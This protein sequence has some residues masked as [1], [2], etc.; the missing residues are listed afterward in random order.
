MIDRKNLE[1]QLRTET[2]RAANAASELEKILAALDAAN[3]KAVLL[4]EM[5]EMRSHAIDHIAQAQLTC[6]TQQ[7]TLTRSLSV[8]EQGASGE[9]RESCQSAEMGALRCTVEIIRDRKRE[10]AA[11]DDHRPAEAPSTVAPMLLRCCYS[12]PRY[13]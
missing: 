8:V 12:C 1:A 5:Q 11:S 4:H 9:L 13:C 3:P 7:N 2:H 10:W 6:L